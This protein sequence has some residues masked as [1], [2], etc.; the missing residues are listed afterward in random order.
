[1]F[2]YF[3]FKEM[4]FITRNVGFFGGW[5]LKFDEFEIILFYFLIERF[6]EVIK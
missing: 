3:V 5:K 1:M 4:S 2:G 6:L